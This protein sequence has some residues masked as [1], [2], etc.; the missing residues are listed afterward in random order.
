MSNEQHEQKA[1]SLFK[2]YEKNSSRYQTKR[3]FELEGRKDEI[4]MQLRQIEAILSDTSKL[5]DED[6]DIYEKR[7]KSLKKFF[8]VEKK[9]NTENIIYIPVR[10]DIKTVYFV[11]EAKCLEEKWYKMAGGKKKMKERIVL[12]KSIL[13]YKPANIVYWNPF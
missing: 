10:L 7:Y 4:L 3:Q 6:L 2:G 13:Q 11:E 8:K 12:F 9:K 5:S 1:F